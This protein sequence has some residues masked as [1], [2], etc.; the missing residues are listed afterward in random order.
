MKLFFFLIII[1]LGCI[2]FGCK[3]WRNC[4]PCNGQTV[5]VYKDTVI[6]RYLP[7]DN[8]KTK[9]GKGDTAKVSNDVSNAIAFIDGDS[10]FLFLWNK[11]EPLEFMFQKAIS[12][13]YGNSASGQ[14]EAAKWWDEKSFLGK[15]EFM[16]LAFVFI[17]LG[18]FVAK[19]IYNLF[20]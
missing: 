7:Q 1:F 2:G 9:V 5:T 6:Y 10:L 14:S 16:V 12:V 17:L 18:A 15:I 4:P 19:L 8:T 11:P 3:A 13:T 20:K